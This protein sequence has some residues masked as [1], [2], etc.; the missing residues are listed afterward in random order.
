MS[1]WFLAVICV[2]MMSTPAQ[3][4]NSNQAVATF[5]GGCFW[6]IEAAFEKVDGVISAVS[7]FTDGHTEDPTYYEVGSG[8]TG[9]TEAVE[10]IYD[11]TKVKYG[12][13]L[14]VFWRNIDPT[15]KNGQFA[16]KGTQYRTGIYYHNDDQKQAAEAS[17]Q[18]LEDSGKFDKPI[19]VEIK[20]ATKFYPADEKHQDYYKKSPGHYQSYHFFSGRGPY[21]K[22]VWGTK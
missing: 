1:K 5:A 12:Q 8:Q 19:V 17:K 3:S 15:Q 11:P 6:C 18:A 2:F 14:N 10:V 16:D 7:G 9:H 13:L 20:P 4:Q 22:K 21:I